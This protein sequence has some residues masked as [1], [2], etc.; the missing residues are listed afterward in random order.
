MQWLNHLLGTTATQ[1]RFPVSECGKDSVRPSKASGFLR[2][3]WFSPPRMTTAGRDSSVN[4][5]AAWDAR[6]TVIDPHF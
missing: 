6:G 3:L 4:S 1:D 2:D 5:D